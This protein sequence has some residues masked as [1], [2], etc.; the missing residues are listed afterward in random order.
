M[1][2]CTAVSV[3][4]HAAPTEDAEIQRQR[5]EAAKQRHFAEQQRRLQEYGSHGGS[6]N[7]NADTMIESILGKSET[8]RQPV[9]SQSKSAESGPSAAASA[10]GETDSVEW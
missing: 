4:K 3:G 1:C 10:I 6:R 9:R 5:A 2:F 7:V 8:A